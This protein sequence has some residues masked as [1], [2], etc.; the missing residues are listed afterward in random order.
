[1]LDLFRSAFA[2]PR[3]LILLVAAA[4]VGIALAD[5]RARR[6]TGSDKA[7]DALIGSMTLAF[8]LGGRVI[9]I[10]AHL[11]AFLASPASVFSLNTSLFD[12]WG[13]FL[14]ATLAAA[15][16][17]QRKRLAAWATLDLLVPFL[18]CLEIGLSLSY[19]A[20]GAA[21]GR[22]TNLPWAIYLWGA[23]RH[24]TQIYELVAGGVTLAV[25]WFCR[26]RTRTGSL[27]LLWVALA[28]ASRLLIEGFRGD[29]ALILG[30]LRLAQ[31]LAWVIL[32]CAL[33]ALELL[34][35]KPG[36]ET[37]TPLP[38]DQLGSAESRSPARVK[39]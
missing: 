31:V 22:E 35:V 1:M 11:Q 29:S 13:G 25:V 3:D 20:S 5:Q 32:A 37:A 38:E 39:R 8:L 19:L 14:C 4:W 34:P 24:P 15:L 16:T 30:G 7:L 6:L 28:A 26:G 36:A 12:V 33:L 21:F 17:I 18:A 2:P 9:F 10:V 23:W 27:F